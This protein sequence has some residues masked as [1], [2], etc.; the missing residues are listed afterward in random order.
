MLARPALGLL[1]LGSIV[2]FVN[3]VGLAA[4]YSEDFS[5]FINGAVGLI[6]GIVFSGLCVK[7]F[8]TAGPG[9]LIA[10]LIRGGWRDVA[11]RARGNAPDSGRWMARMLDRIGL[12][13]PRLAQQEADPGRPL[14]DALVD[15]R[16]GYVSGELAALRKTMTPDEEQP[17]SATLAEIARYFGQGDPGSADPP[18][19]ALLDGIDRSVGAFAHDPVRE[20]R[21]AGLL[22]LTSLRRNLFPTAPPWEAVAA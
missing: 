15:L 6:A 20:R 19:P 9:N 4:T 8:L 7:L 17:V 14:L 3:S 12:L 2:G 13:A 21:R 22:L 11:Q 16:I 1:A 5:G 18:P 10:R